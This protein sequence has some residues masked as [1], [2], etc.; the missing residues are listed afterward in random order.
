MRFLRRTMEE[1]TSFMAIQHKLSTSKPSIFPMFSG[2]LSNFKH[3]KRSRELS[4]FKLQMVLGRHTRFT[5]YLKVN[6]VRLVKCSIDEGNPSIA[7]LLKS[8][9]SRPLIFHGFSGKFLNLKHLEWLRAP[10]NL[11]PQVVLGR[12]ASLESLLQLNRVNEVR[13]VRRSID[14]GNSFIAVWLRLR[15]LRPSRFLKFLG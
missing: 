11:K 6:R 2:K 3:P 4:N 13:L 15:F 1:G 10:W 8:S 14:E 7:I 9:F 5:Q 12:H